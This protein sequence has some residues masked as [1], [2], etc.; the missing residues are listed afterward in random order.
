M[1]N[2]YSDSV[3]T[4]VEGS[5]QDNIGLPLSFEYFRGMKSLDVIQMDLFLKLFMKVNTAV[6]IGKFC[7]NI[8]YALG[9]AVVTK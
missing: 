4:Y 5:C 9:K 1:Q 8:V 6:F 7:L 2:P 3:A